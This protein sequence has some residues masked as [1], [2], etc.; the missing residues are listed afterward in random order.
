MHALHE[1]REFVSYLPS[2]NRDASP[3]VACSD[4]ADRKVLAL[5]Q[6]IPPESTTP[7]DMKVIIGFFYESNCFVIGC[8]QSTYR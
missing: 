8:Y 2:S 6:I 5:E 7:Y 1:L 3:Q 4:P